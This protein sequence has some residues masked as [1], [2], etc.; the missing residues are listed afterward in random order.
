MRRSRRDLEG[1][2]TVSAEV[3]GCTRYTAVG[4]SPLCPKLDQSLSPVGSRLPALGSRRFDNSFQTRIQ[5]IGP[6]HS[7]AEVSARIA[8]PLGSSAMPTK[9][10]QLRWFRSEATREMRSEPAPRH[11]RLRRCPDIGLRLPSEPPER[12]RCRDSWSQR[13]SDPLDKLPLQAGLYRRRGC[14]SRLG[15]V[16][17]THRLSTPAPAWSLSVAAPWLV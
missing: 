7:A 5:R 2:H 6:S 14:C 15:A 13:E 17:G 4:P 3:V 8:V 10:Q 12:R 16:P 1:W 11:I 9:G